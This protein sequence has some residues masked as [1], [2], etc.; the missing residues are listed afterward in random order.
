MPSRTYPD[1][2]LFITHISATPQT[3]ET[4]AREVRSQAA[5]LIEEGINT[6]ELERARKPAINELK[7]QRQSNRYWL[8]TVMSGLSRY[9]EQVQ[10][11]RDA[12]GILESLTAQ[13]LGNLTKKYLQPGLS[14]SFIVTSGE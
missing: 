12:Q 2:G 5:E 9:P 1:F 11:S 3:T 6:D 8:G 4:I 7:E 10:W 14:A 13:E